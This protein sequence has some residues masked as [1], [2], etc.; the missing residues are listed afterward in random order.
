MMTESLKTLKFKT[1]GCGSVSNIIK[2]INRMGKGQS[3]N[4]VEKIKNS[5]IDRRTYSLPPVKIHC[6]VLDPKMIIKTDI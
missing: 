3:L 2:F 6:S 1:Y 5:D 4:K